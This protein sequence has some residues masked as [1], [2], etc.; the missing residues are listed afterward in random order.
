MLLPINWLKDYTNIKLSTEKLA[1]ILRLKSFE[2]ES[3]SAGG[4]KV[5]GVIVAEVL[6]VKKHPNADK[7]KLTRLSDGKREYKVVCGAPNVE[8]GQRVPL[9]V[10][11]AKLP[12]GMEIIKREVRGEV[13][14]GMICAADELGIGTD[15][16]GILVL[17]KNAKL[18]D[19]AD[20]YFDNDGGPVIEFKITPDRADCLSI[21]GLA[22]EV[23]AL[24]GSGLKLPEMKP[25][26]SKIHATDAVS[27]QILDKDLCPQYF[28]RVIKNVK[29]GESSKW[30]Q[31]RLKAV[32]LRPIN[33]VVDITNFVL[34]EFG[35]P[36]HAFDAAKV[37][38]A[39]FKKLFVRKAKKGEK[40]LALDGKIYELDSDIAV[41][42]DTKNPLAIAGIM[43]GEDPAVKENTTDIIL[44]AAVFDPS[45]IRKA[46]R[47]L[48]LRSDSSSQ[49]EKGFDP[50]VTEAALNRAALL[51]QEI[52]GGEV[53]KGSVSPAI[54][55]SKKKSV[56]L[57]VAYLNKM[58]GME[59]PR[60]KVKS[61][62]LSH[63]FI[64]KEKGKDLEVEIPS[65]RRDV[66]READLV[67]E[68]ARVYGYNELPEKYLEA[69]L[70]P[71]AENLK[72][73]WENKI[74]ELL[75]RAGF[76]EIYNYSFY[77][78][79]EISILNLKAE[80]H[81]ELENPMNP[82]Q[83]YMRV[84]L[85]PLMFKSVSEN[86]R[87]FDEIKMFEIGRVFLPK[88]AGMPEEELRVGAVIS[89]KLLDDASL[90]R[91]LLGAKKMILENLGAERGV[92][93]QIGIFS[94]FEKE[95][96]KLK[97]GLVYFEMNLEKLMQVAGGEKK[98]AP[99][100]AYPEV[101]RD[102]SVIIPE[103]KNWEEIEET[104]RKSAGNILNS[105]ELFDLYRGKGVES[106]RKSVAFHLIF[107]SNER[108]LTSEEVDGAMG[109]V[110][111]NLENK[112][113]A[114]LRS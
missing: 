75:V 112:L 48:G 91:E 103:D 107:S 68:V 14:E 46:A 57:P 43:G 23:S 111:K 80:G 36:L 55:K 70:V 59:I 52:C 30:M 18:G 6:E 15:H 41:I 60:A 90:Y 49:F 44:E 17:P 33:N 89:S 83:K 42:A 66:N 64:V 61:I 3:I 109:A 108:T 105:V 50:A 26:E 113:D 69:E 102:L 8:V 104:V 85:L 39:K 21:L 94:E 79:K 77:G 78:D 4:P 63:G 29:V 99:V 97:S 51:V 25:K 16:S 76:N 54:I 92:E 101:A 40:I 1:D 20:Q 88:G 72:H 13:S 62:L 56:I 87:R 12:N 5:P 2:V 73:N 32:G 84:S 22:R 35:Q 98:Y 106:G 47:K 34:F 114:K 11:G 53:L 37:A 27:I 74:R 65:W 67:E 28:A 19:D 38:G 95:Q 71:P 93:T 81:L 110:V 24:T 9:A 7:L 31:E 96:W 45:R 82:D 58:I 100:S 10:E 86:A